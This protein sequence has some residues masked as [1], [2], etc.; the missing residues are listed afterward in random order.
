MRYCHATLFPALCA[1]Y[2]ERYSKAIARNYNNPDSKYHWLYKEL[3]ERVTT[4]SSAKLFLEALPLFMKEDETCERSLS[5]AT[6]F[7]ADLFKDIPCEK[8]LQEGNPYWDDFMEAVENIDRKAELAFQSQVPQFYLALCEYV[9][10]CIRLYFYVR[11]KVICAIDRDKFDS[12][13]DTQLAVP[14]QF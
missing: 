10:R 12:V 7:I 9:V 2:S 13:M 6:S 8:L 5:Y 14:A 1:Y 3:S 4:L 11:E